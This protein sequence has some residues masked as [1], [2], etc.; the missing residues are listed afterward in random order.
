MCHVG[1]CTLKMQCHLT[2]KVWYDK[3]LCFQA[4]NYF[5]CLIF[6]LILL[7]LQ[8]LLIFNL[9]FHSIQV[10]CSNIKYAQINFW[11]GAGAFMAERV[12]T[13]IYHFQIL[14]NVSRA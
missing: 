8:F 13:E 6:L 1:L 12:H 7:P 4:Y 14:T 2:N 10:I 11:I 9:V 3:I 5:Y